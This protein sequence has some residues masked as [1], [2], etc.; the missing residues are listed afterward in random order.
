M[1]VNPYTRLK[2][3]CKKY[4]DEVR[5]PHTRNM[6]HYPKSRLKEGWTLTDLWERTAAAE[7]LGYDVVLEAQ[8]KGL[9]VKYVKKR[10]RVPWELQ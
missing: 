8:D 9:L 5:Y 3:I 6:W 1:R 4:A 2:G 7:Q 10:P